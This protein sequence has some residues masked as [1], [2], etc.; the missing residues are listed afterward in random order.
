MQSTLRWFGP[1]DDSVSLEYIRQIP[2]VAGVVSALQEI[3]VGEVWSL[4][5]ILERKKLI[6][7]NGLKLL[8]IESVNIHEEIKLK[9]EDTPRL[10]KNYKECIKNLSEAGINMICYNFMPVFDWA[11]SDLAKVL[12]D[13]S[14]VLSYDKN[15]IE[16]KTPEEMFEWINGEARGY[17]LPGWEKEKFP[18]LK[19]LFKRYKGI[20][21]DDLFA[22]LEHFLKEVIPVAEEYNVK[23]AIHPDD[24]PWGI[25]G[26][27]RITTTEKNIEKIL[28]LVDS[29]SNGLTFCSGSLG[30][31]QDNDLPNMIR[32][33]GKK[34]NFV[35]LRNVKIH[36]QGVFDEASH[37]SKD[38]SIDMFE[39]VKALHDIN[40]SGL[41]RPDHG[42]MVWGEKAR[43]GYG[44]Y[45]RAMGVAYLNG[46]W[47]AIEKSS[48]NK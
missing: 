39:L 42:R 24:P 22:H 1:N 27:P 31:R 9:G 36:E 3:P 4:E 2:N 34:I 28:N 12:K 11:R 5:K 44:L 46:L 40:Y 33:F 25:F 35:H 6:E 41:M 30:A 8:G 48:K 21:E 17:S 7:A 15:I 20:T 29:Q 13:G 38:G 45:D 23:L 26:L 43:P 10:I 18:M 47:E 32:K 16:G 19:E 37:L 14:N